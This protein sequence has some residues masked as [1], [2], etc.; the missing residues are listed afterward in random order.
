MY[1]HV[2]TWVGNYV[3]LHIIFTSVWVFSG[4]NCSLGHCWWPT[5]QYRAPQVTCSALP[6]TQADN[7]LPVSLYPIVLHPI[8]PP[9]SVGSYGRWI[10]LCMRGRG[11]EGYCV[12]SELTR[13]YIRM[14][15]CTYMCLYC[16]AVAYLIY[17]YMP[18]LA[19][20]S[21][22]TVCWS[23]GYNEK[24]RTLKSLF[25]QVSARLD[26]RCTYVHVH[27]YVRTYVYHTVS[28]YSTYLFVSSSHAIFTVMSVILWRLVV[29]FN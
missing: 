2:R 4:P 7:Q 28:R 15:V 24:D 13:T 16:T 22:A 26:F 27:T 14:C 3:W 17:K 9:P 8:P 5:V 12:V 10:I 29:A 20:Y 25:G 19:L 23:S 21:S 6:C 18:V 11:G 1:I